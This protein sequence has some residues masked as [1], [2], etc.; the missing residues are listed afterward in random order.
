M[1]SG[2]HCATIGGHLH[3]IAPDD[4]ALVLQGGS[5][6]AAGSSTPCSS[7]GCTAGRQQPET[8]ATS[9]FSGPCSWGCP[10]G[11]S[12]RGV[13]CTSHTRHHHHGQGV[14]CAQLLKGI[15]AWHWLQH[16]QCSLFGPHKLR[17]IALDHCAM[18]SCRAASGCLQPHM[19]QLRDHGSG[20]TNIAASAGFSAC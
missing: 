13:C 11:C 7:S 8:A 12:R 15:H 4:Q 14:W 3:S 20:R 6:P 9:C 16:K 18:L 5:N 17:N 2:K 19:Q 1:P 10:A